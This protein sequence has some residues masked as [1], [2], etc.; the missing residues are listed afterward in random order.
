MFMVSIDV[1]NTE[2]FES[3]TESETVEEINED[4]ESESTSVKDA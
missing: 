3:Q 1:H 2:Q 4:R